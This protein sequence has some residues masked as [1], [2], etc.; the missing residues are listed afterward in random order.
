M[1]NLLVFRFIIT[2]TLLACLA[3]ALW[4]QGYVWPV[5]EGG[6]PISYFILGLFV[7]AWA[8]SL[9]ETIVVSMALNDNKFGGAEPALIAEADKDI[10]KVEWLHAIAGW[11]AHIGL[12]GTAIGLAVA[13]N[14]FV[15]VDVS[16]ASDALQAMANFGQGFL[17][18]IFTTIL[19]GALGLWQE[20]NFQM[21]KTAMT[22]YWSD[23]LAANQGLGTIR[24][25][26]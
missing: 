5:I 19:G 9:K 26:D 18:A 4:L 3:G 13:L 2:N 15:G 21:L 8:W 14:G 24:G 16:S 11:M 6:A 22:V 12:L 7:V 17:L 10:A 25:T 1:S 23:R 20:F